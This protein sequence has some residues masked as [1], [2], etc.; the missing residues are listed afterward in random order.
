VGR[1]GGGE[2]EEEEERGSVAVKIA[3]SYSEDSRFEYPKDKKCIEILLSFFRRMHGCYRQT[4]PQPLMFI[5][6]TAFTHIKPVIADNTECIKMLE[7]TSRMSYS[8][9]NK[10]K[11]RINMPG[12]ECCLSLIERLHSTVHTL[13]M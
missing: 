6:M 5:P 3:A 8:H 12:N 2:E 11:V 4:M 1:G 13:T 10:E 7:Q 9:Q